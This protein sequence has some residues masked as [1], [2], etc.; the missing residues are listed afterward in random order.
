MGD[1]NTTNFVRVHKSE[2][3]GPFLEVGS[4]DYGS[5]SDLSVL[6]PGETYTRVDMSAGK[7][8]DRVIDM[9][10]PFNQVDFALGGLRFGTIFCLCVLEHCDQLFKM[11]GNL[12]RL[13]RPGG[14]ICI[15][16]PFAWKFH[17][18]P[19]DY[20][21]FTHEGVRKLFA[22]LDFDSSASNATTSRL[23]ESYPLNNEIGRIHLHGSHHRKNGHFLRG[24]SADLLRLACKLGILRWLI[25]YRYVL[26]PTQVNM[27]GARPEG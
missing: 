10:L 4:R 3:Q 2:F 7:S 16:V 25:G 23:G 15:S 17:G 8:V 22:D 19:S 9:T 27:I 26:T 6:F 5:T 21:R 12:A 13:L 14:K 20:W 11:A 1:I 24:L 18:Y